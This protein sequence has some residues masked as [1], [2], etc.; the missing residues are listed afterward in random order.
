MLLGLLFSNNI[1]HVWGI[2]GSHEMLC[3]WA[4]IGADFKCILGGKLAASWVPSWTTLTTTI[5][6]KLIVFFLIFKFFNFYF[7]EIHGNTIILTL[8]QNQDYHPWISWG[9]PHMVL[10]LRKSRIQCFKWFSNLSWNEGDIT[11]WSNVVQR[12]CFFGLTLGQ[13]LFGCLGLILGLLLG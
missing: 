3:F 12:A 13:L 1:D 8:T 6:M 7:F 5:D 4:M 9:R 11:G 2:L 10:K